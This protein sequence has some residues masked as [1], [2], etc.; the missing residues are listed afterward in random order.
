MP[1]GEKAPWLEP[2]IG[3]HDTVDI[4][5]RARPGKPR[6]KPGGGPGGVGAGIQCIRHLLGQDDGMALGQLEHGTHTGDQVQ[7]N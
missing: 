7:T 6:C 2:Q 4:P 1:I 3:G 5:E